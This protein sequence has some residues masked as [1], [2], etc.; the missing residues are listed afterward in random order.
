MSESPPSDAAPAD[1]SIVL[2][3]AH[4]ATQRGASPYT[5]RNYRQTL[6]EFVQWRQ[7][8]QRQ[9][10][11]W[12]SLQ[13]DDFRNYLRFLGR[14]KMSRAAIQLRFSALRSFYKFLIRRGDAETSP[15]KNLHPPK[16]GKRL[17]RFLTARQMLDLLKA[18]QTSS[19]GSPQKDGK[20]PP[21]RPVESS[22]P[23]R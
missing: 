8:E 11:V 22:V 7:D 2:F 1:A 12:K 10:L 3:L 19:A 16:M 4:L 15:I 13:R 17:P 6:T 5:L 9:A 18:P 21:G 14:S 20:L 23:E